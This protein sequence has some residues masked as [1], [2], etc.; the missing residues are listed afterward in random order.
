ML[1]YPHITF[2]WSC[3]KRVKC[4]YLTQKKLFDLLQNTLWTPLEQIKM[5]VKFFICDPIWENRPC[6]ARDEKWD[7]DCIHIY[8]ISTSSYQNLKPLG[9]VVSELW[10]NKYR[11]FIAIV[12][13]KTSL[14]ALLSTSATTPYTIRVIIEQM[15]VVIFACKSGICMSR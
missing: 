7:Y 4:E 1:V 9:A 8:V 2:M 14:N 15:F 11:S 13:A 6:T 10:A 5:Y 3:T 12:F